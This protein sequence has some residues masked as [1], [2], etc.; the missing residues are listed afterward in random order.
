[1][2]KQLK[3]VYKDVEYTLEFTRRTVEQMEREG[4]V[5]EDVKVKPMTSLPT[6]FAGAFKAHHRFVKP[7]TIDEI[8]AKMTD[9]AGLI[10]A[11]AAMYNEPLMAL[12]EE[13]EESPENLNWTQSW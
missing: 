2:S 12:L 6:L 4:F 11:L 3:F 1:M 13:P 5:A 9:K 7:D 8:Y 10:A